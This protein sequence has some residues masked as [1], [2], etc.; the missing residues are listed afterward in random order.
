ML[1][2]GDYVIFFQLVVRAPPLSQWPLQFLADRRTRF[3][4][5][6][7]S[8]HSMHKES[9]P[10]MQT[11]GRNFE[12]KSLITVQEIRVLKRKHEIRVWGSRPS[13][14]LRSRDRASWGCLYML[15][16][17]RRPGSTRASVPGP[18]AQAPVLASQIH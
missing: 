7:T 16:D 8:M 18:F 2:G 9:K 11:P 1:V 14:K 15:R 13:H 3:S 17:G 5:E 6:Q 10:A 4:G 12:A